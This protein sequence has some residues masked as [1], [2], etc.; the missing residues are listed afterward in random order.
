MPGLHFEMIERV[1][2]GPRVREEE[3][4]KTIFPRMKELAEKY[5]I[6]YDAAHPIPSDDGMADR[7]FAASLI[8]IYS[9]IVGILTLSETV[10]RTRLAKQNPYP[11]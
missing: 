8:I 11:A 1:D 7:L 6:K 9:F 3:F 2:Q 5:E 10:S 4:D